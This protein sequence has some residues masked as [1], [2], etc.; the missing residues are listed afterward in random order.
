MQ[1]LQDREYCCTQAG[2]AEAAPGAGSGPCAR[3]WCCAPVPSRCVL[4]PGALPGRGDDL[5]L[6]APGGNA[7]LCALER[8]GCTPLASFTATVSVPWSPARC[9]RRHA[10]NNPFPSQGSGRPGLLEQQLQEDVASG[11]C[12]QVGT[13]SG[14]A[15]PRGARA[16]R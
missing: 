14:H 10:A 12:L 2:G 7:S 6:M 9:H 4:S 8:G 13:G 16:G 1:C 3:I 15:A 11:Q 5:L